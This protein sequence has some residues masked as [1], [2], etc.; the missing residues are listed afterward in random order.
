MKKEFLFSIIFFIVFVTLISLLFIFQP[1]IKPYNSYP[2]N[3]VTRII[4]GDTF[5]IYS[6]ETIR[7]LCVDTPEQSEEGFEEAKLFLED[8]ILNKEV[9]L[10]SSVTDRDSYDRLLRYVYINE[11]FVNKEILNEG[12]GMLMIIP[13]EECKELEY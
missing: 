8:L 9:I 11:T 6:G 4:D 7:L 10:N 1:I 13:P 5:E 12:Y 3:Y 2:D